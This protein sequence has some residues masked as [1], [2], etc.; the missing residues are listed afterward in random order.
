[1]KL[2]TTWKRFGG[3]HGLLTMTHYRIGSWILYKVRIPIVKHILWFTHRTI[4]LLFVRAFLGT[5][6]P[7]QCQIGKELHLPHGGIGVMI[8]PNAKIGN[9]VTIFH[10]VTLGIKNQTGEAPTIGN[11]VF[12]GA[13]AKI[14]GNI[15]IGD[16]SVIGANAVVTKDVPPNSTAFGV[17]AI[18]IPNKNKPKEIT[19]D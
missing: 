13:G 12:I 7:A 14:L 17:P 18:A 9:N 15:K 19:T 2:I 10:Q 16:N 3:L 8:H 6:I 11:D 5:L 1:M 4:E